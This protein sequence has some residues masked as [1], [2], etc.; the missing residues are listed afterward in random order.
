[1]SAR[2]RFRD[3]W[4]TVGRAPRGKGELLLSPVIAG[5][6]PER[7]VQVYLPPGY[8]DGHER[9]PVLYLQDGQNLFDPATAFAGSWHAERA[10]DRLAHKGRP[11]IAVAIP[12]AGV[13]RI[14]EYAPYRDRRYGG[15][16][17][18]AYLDWLTERVQP[19]VERSFRVLREAE[20]TAIAGASMGG[21][22]SLYAFWSRRR[23]FG[24]VG[25]M[26]PS[27]FFA[28]EAL[29]CGIE[30]HAPAAG[31]AYLD[32]GTLEGRRNRRRK[33]APKSP[34]GA[35]KRLRRLRRGLERSGFRLGVDLEWIEE[36]GGRH[37]EAAWSRRLPGMLEFLFPSP[38]AR[39]ATAQRVSRRSSSA[40]A[41]GSS[42]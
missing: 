37:D 26:S 32:I 7:A 4:E 23:S 2:A 22:I 19:L 9:F 17:A 34:S 42:D 36:A 25:A 8:R 35:M 20:S 14:H 6:V 16:G 10:L 27:L 5:E 38:G 15:G 3:Y 39:P 13:R 29:T 12:N 18:E 33:T 30:R 1:M 11:V 40:V 21:L 24:L 41:R 28:E 31:R